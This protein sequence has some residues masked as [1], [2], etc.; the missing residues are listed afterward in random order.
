M[1][2]PEFEMEG[3]GN[4]EQVTQLAHFVTRDPIQSVEERTDQALHGTVVVGSCVPR[5]AG[6]VCGDGD[7]LLHCSQV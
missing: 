5:L 1:E 2:E 6:W 7:G 3:D 4:E